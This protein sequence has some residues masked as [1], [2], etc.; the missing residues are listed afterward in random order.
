MKNPVF[1]KIKWTFSDGITLALRNILALIRNPESLFFSSVQPVMF[2][3]LFRYVFGGAIGM[4]LPKTVPYVD[5]LMPGIFVQTVAFGSFGTS[6]GLAE[7]LH[8]GLIERFRA[9]PMSRSAV[10]IGRTTAD[11][12]RNTFVIVLMTGVGY[13]VGFRIETN[14]ISYI[15]GVLLILF[16]SYALSWGL[17]FVGLSAPNSETAQ[18]MSFPL[19]FPLTFAS[20]AFVPPITMPSWL[21][22][23]ATYQPISLLSTA[24]RS[25]MATGHLSVDILLRAIAWCLGA[26]VVFMFLAI[27]KYRKVT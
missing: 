16:F 7:D 14:I 20:S 1:L 4:A 5:Y 6:V 19:L 13:L 27:N 10:L 3:V 24:A 22:G 18:V 17:A 2:V 25:L 26:L 11:L 9:L 23:F 8:K 21:Q 15:E 12:I